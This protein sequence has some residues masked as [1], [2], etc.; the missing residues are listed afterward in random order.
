MGVDSLAPSK[1][2]RVKGIQQGWSDAEIMENITERDELFKKLRKSCMHVE[3]NNYKEAR[4]E[5]QKLIR[6][7]K[8]AYFERKLTGNLCERV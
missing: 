1:N 6:T 4:N 5:R 8:N 7:K 2:K 3:K